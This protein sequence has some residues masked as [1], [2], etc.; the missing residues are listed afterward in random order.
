[1]AR[2]AMGVPAFGA[3]L[4]VADGP[5]K[6]A[7]YGS[8]SWAPTLDLRAHIEESRAYASLASKRMRVF[9][10]VTLMVKK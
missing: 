2:F 7:R 4:E 8:P 10:H 1:M 9:G 6:S 3:A 5:G